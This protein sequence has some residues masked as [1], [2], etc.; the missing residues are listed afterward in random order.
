MR[1]PHHTHQSPGRRGYSLLEVL[2]T[3]LIIHIISGIVVV[4]VSNI[5]TSEKLSRAGE[6]VI[7]AA[8]YAR[9]LAM[10][11]GQ[12]AGIEFDSSTN[13]VRVFQGASVATAAN[14][15]IP[16][17][18]YILNFNTRSEVLGVRT[19]AATIVGST[20]NPYRVTFGTLGGTNNTGSITLSYGSQPKIVQV[21]AVGDPT[22]R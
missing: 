12:T 11:T 4:N 8:R 22:L 18:F 10:T 17:G 1:H 15:L 2:I 7:A 14:S 9:M 21:P 13:Q 19:T 16:G 5:Q 20:T 6:E 3:V